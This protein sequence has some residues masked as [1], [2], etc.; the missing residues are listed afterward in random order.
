MKEYTAEEIIDLAKREAEALAEETRK[1]LQESLER[2]AKL[3]ED[4]IARTLSLV[5]D[6]Y[7]L[8]ASMTPT[9]LYTTEFLE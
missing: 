3:A 7:E 1:A 6:A 2:R 8:E 5:S 4:K 9:D